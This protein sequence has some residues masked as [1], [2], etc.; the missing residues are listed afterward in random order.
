MSS[1]LSP[2]TPGDSNPTTERCTEGRRRAQCTTRH[3]PDCAYTDSAREI[4]PILLAT[5]PYIPEIHDDAEPLSPEREQ[6]ICEAAYTAAVERLR[7]IYSGQV[8]DRVARAIADA[9]LDAIR[10]VL[11]AEIRAKALREAIDAAQGEFLNDAT[12]DPEDSAYDRGV[13]DA[14]FAIETLLGDI[15]EGGAR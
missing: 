3:T 15:P 5:E 9:V 2:A 1:S 12:G 7:S 8:P 13:A 14:V 6:E 4:L 10:P 11:L